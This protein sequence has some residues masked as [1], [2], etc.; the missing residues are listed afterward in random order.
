[1]TGDFGVIYSNIDPG[2]QGF[3]NAIIRFENR[4]LDIFLIRAI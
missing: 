3:K 1:M 2:L 4:F